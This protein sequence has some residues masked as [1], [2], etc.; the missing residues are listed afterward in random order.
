MIVVMRPQALPAEI[1]GVCDLIRSQGLEA[2]VSEG[3]ER[4][5]MGVVGRD[6]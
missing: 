5:I 1:D 3:Q 2:F 4:V 6:I